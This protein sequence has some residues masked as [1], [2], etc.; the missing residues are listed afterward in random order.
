MAIYGNRPIMGNYQQP[1]LQSGPVASP[2]YYGGSNPNYGNMNLSGYVSK[3]QNAADTAY[4]MKGGT[5]LVNQALGK[6]G[7]VPGFANVQ[8]LLGSSG[9]GAAIGKAIPFVG[10]ALGAKSTL[11][12]IQAGSVK[13][14][15][16]SGA[17]TGASIGSIVPG[18]GTVIG[19][20]IGGVVGGVGAAIHGKTSHSE[21]TWDAYKKQA[22]TGAMNQLDPGSAGEV[23]KG[24]WDTNQAALGAKSWASKEDFMQKM[25]AAL[26]SSG[27]GAGATPQQVGQFIQQWASQNGANVGKN[28][29]PVL[30]NSLGDIGSRFL[31]GQD[32]GTNSQLAGKINL[33]MFQQGQQGAAQPQNFQ[34]MQQPSTGAGPSYAMPQGAGLGWNAYNQSNPFA[35]FAARLQPGN[36]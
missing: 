8:N 14:G 7:S 35:A 18:L 1:V 30:W 26:A 5:A 10:A 3:Y 25:G 22:G 23:F 17:A 24:L 16:L 29:S 28:Q 6:T 2:S 34:A 15:A 21:L 19:G 9:A 27:L 12:A 20:V 31:Q 13:G 36:G 11:Q 33:G 4:T 32:V